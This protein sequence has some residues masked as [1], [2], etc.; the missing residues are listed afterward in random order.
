MMI[1]HRTIPQ[2]NMRQ[3]KIR[4]PKKNWKLAKKEK[5]LLTHKN[6]HNFLFW[7]HVWK[8]NEKNVWENN[9]NNF[10]F[11]ATCWF[12]HDFITFYFIFLFSVL[13]IHNMSTFIGTFPHYDVIFI[14]FFL[15]VFHVVVV[16]Y[17]DVSHFIILWL[18]NYHETVR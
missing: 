3:K 2:K 16:Y 18:W 12:K 13:F 11:A 17:C 10:S 4:K 5:N 7:R 1:Q 8:P 15:G 14:Y 6:F 9:K